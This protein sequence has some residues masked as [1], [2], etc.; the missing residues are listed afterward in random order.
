MKIVSYSDND[1]VTWC[2]PWED[3]KVSLRPR[4]RSMCLRDGSVVSRRSGTS[5]IVKGQQRR[6]KK[7]DIIGNHM[8]R[9]RGWNHFMNW[10]KRIRGERQAHGAEARRMCL[11][12]L[13]SLSSLSEFWEPAK[14]L[15][16][17]GLFQVSLNTQVH[18]TSE[19]KD[20][21]R[22]PQRERLSLFPF[23]A[24]SRTCSRMNEQHSSSKVVLSKSVH[25][26]I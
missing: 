14:V 11:Y 12:R 7:Y 1:H 5:W 8:W 19:L 3:S 17:V 23:F 22:H 26:L 4:K 20:S 15:L 13:Q 25:L 21:Q 16:R 10:E 9:G 18:H 2:V 24:L 6:K